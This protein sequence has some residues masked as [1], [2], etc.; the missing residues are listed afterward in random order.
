METLNSQF[1]PTM[2]TEKTAIRKTIRELKK[3]I[4]PA[5]DNA[6]ALEMA[7]FSKVEM[8]PEYEHSRNIMIYHSLSDEFPTHHTITRM[9]RDKNIFLPRVCGED[10]EI[11]PYD[12]QHPL[13][14]GAYGIQEPT[15]DTAAVTPEQID[16]IIVPGVAFDTQGNRLGRGKGY[17]DRI[18]SHTTATL[19]GVCYDFQ[20]LDLLPTEIHDVKM[21]YIVTPN[22][23]INTIHSK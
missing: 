3:I 9:A 2:T 7:L 6:S 23:F 14:T 18:L 4:I 22:C 12:A 11:L 21:Q 20:L 1:S 19:V 5:I 15:G 13:E 17:Y 8:L 10:L 16:L